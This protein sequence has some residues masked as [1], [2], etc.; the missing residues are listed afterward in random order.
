MTT[1][2]LKRAFIQ[3]LW[4]HNLQV[5]Q[6][7]VL[8]M[9]YILANVIVLNILFGVNVAADESPVCVVSSELAWKPSHPC[10]RKRAVV[11]GTL[12]GANY[13]RWQDATS[14]EPR[15]AARL[16]RSGPSVYLISR[17]E[18][19][20]SCTGQPVEVIGKLEIEGQIK[21]GEYPAK[22][23][24]ESIRCESP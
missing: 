1:Q 4:G 10:N 3:V 20:P 16:R 21:G 17:I 19:E 11:R 24:V 18:F 6:D 22:L 12:E 8:K 23:Q 5:Y 2:L 15:F 9:I 14:K 13:Q 7:G